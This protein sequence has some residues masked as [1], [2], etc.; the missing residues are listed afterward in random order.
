MV[1]KPPA[2][3]PTCWMCY[4]IINLRVSLE[5]ERIEEG[6]LAPFRVHLGKAEAKRGRGPCSY[7]ASPPSSIVSRG[8]GKAKHFIWFVS[9]LT[10]ADSK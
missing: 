1:P 8:V 5:M 9:E 3:P 6:I 2:C 10:Q 4:D 7:L